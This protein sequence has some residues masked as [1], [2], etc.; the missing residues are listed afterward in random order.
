MNSLEHYEALLSDRHAI[1]TCCATVFESKYEAPP[2]VPIWWVA[3]CLHALKCQR[4]R[5]ANH[6]AVTRMMPVINAAS[7]NMFT[8]KTVFDEPDMR[9]ENRRRF[10]TPGC[11]SCE[12]F[13]A[14]RIWGSCRRILSHAFCNVVRM[15]IDLRSPSSAPFGPCVDFFDGLP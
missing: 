11:R 8:S 9:R 7:R 10:C 13:P 2:P 6:Q 5:L 15:H 14:P 4:C 3:D 1:V 12:S